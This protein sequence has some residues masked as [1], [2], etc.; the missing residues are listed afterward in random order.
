M[1]GFAIAATVSVMI[2]LAP[3][4]LWSVWYARV[5]GGLVHLWFWSMIEAFAFALMIWIVYKSTP[6]YVNCPFCAAKVEVE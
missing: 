4:W 1:K 3:C 6:K 2:G 5:G